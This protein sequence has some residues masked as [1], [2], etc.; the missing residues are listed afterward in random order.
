MDVI[1]LAC[2]LDPEGSV[3]ALDIKYHLA[4]VAVYVYGKSLLQGSGGKAETLKRLL[5][6]VKGLLGVRHRL[7]GAVL[8]IMEL[9]DALRA[10]RFLKRNGARTMVL[11]LPRG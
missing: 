10:L 2:K 11:R 6:V 1:R 8:S 5:E 4:S 3:R 7:A 9:E